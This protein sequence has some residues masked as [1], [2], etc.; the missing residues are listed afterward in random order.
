VTGRVA[1]RI[2]TA[3]L[4][5]LF[6]AGLRLIAA[7]FALDDQSRTGPW[8]TGTRNDLITGGI[9][10]VVSALGLLI[11]TIAA[12]RELYRRYRHPIQIAGPSAT[13]DHLAT[14]PAAQPST[15]TEPEN[16]HGHR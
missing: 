11:V 7:P 12:V 13:G 3:G 1:A 5:V 8:L 16:Y 4:L 2:A 15:L 14:L 9:L 6:L 10:A